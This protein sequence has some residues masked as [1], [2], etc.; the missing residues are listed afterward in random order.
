M[1]CSWAYQPE[2]NEWKFRKADR[3]I[4][5]QAPTQTRHFCECGKTSTRF[6]AEQFD[7]KVWVCANCFVAKENARNGQATT[8]P[9]H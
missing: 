2:P 9:A 1:P 8:P 3:V 5:H 4:H 6:I 7:S